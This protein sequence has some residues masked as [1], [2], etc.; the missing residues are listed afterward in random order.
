MSRRRTDHRG[1]ALPPEE[2]DRLALA[3]HVA[4]AVAE[5][6]A[7][8][9]VRD[10]EALHALWL[11]ER[12]FLTLADVAGLLGCS[13]DTAAKLFKAK[14]LRGV[15]LGGWRTTWADLQRAYERGF[16]PDLSTDRGR[17]SA[18]KGGRPR[19]TTN[20]LK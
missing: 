14:R 16:E 7:G 17:P 6:V 4:A 8:T 9:L 11:Q 15:K 19:A 10:A 12:R 2:R 1:R 20:G 3:E 5:R 13:D 18:K